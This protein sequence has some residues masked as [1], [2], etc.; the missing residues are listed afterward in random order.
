MQLIYLQQSGKP[1]E[2]TGGNFW[3]QAGV[4]VP[5]EKWK[6]LQVRVNGLLK[7]FHK[8]GYDPVRTKLDAN[9]LLHPRNAQKR[10]TR[11]LCKGF[12]KIVAGLELRFFLVVID[13]RTTDKPAHPRWILPL[14]YHY[15]MKAIAQYLREQD[16]VGT[17]I[18]PP[19]RP[20]EEEVLS[21]IQIENLFGYAGRFSPLIGAPLVQQVSNSCGL[22]VADFV[23][24][25]ARRYHEE[26]YPKLFAKQTLFRYD[27]IINSH[28]QG[29]VKPA[30]Y[31]SPVTDF[32]GYKIRGYIYLWRR[33]ARGRMSDDQASGTE[34]DVATVSSRI[35]DSGGE[36]D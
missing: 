13:K 26:V 2:G 14:S 5:D 19:G 16:D 25:I 11:A 15:L 4:A 12:E 22:Q 7:S 32:R 29:F 28:Y 3:V 30:T 24:T 36:N 33:D 31:H 17:L 34:I 21:T 35:R 27:A 18:I 23:A 1:V 6:E 8:V 9:D 20:E 10:Y